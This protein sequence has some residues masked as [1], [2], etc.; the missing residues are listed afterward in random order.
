MQKFLLSFF[1]FLS[2]FCLSPFASALPQEH[3]AWHE[4]NN[5]YRTMYDRYEIAMQRAYDALS[6]DAY[7]KLEQDND[8]VID[9]SAK[10]A[11]DND[12]AFACAQALAERVLVVEEMVSKVS[13]DQ[14]EGTPN[15]L[16][17]F[18]RLNGR[19]GDD[20]Y[21]TIS[22]DG[23]GGFCLEIGVWQKDAPQSFGW[24][25]AQSTTLG[26]NFSTTT[27]YQPQTADEISA[28]DVQLKITVKD[29]KAVITTTE[30]FRKGGYVW[31]S[32]GE[33]DTIKN[34]FLDGTYQR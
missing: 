33:E 11:S 23:N 24:T 8:A 30:A 25:Q 17:G 21:L 1:L 13:Q 7:K 29:G 6:E 5:D 34:I 12:A 20:G 10:N 32:K 4:S 19:Q 22:R 27:V 14:L 2:S 9:A 26:E 16:E 3:D 15:P 18:Y 28:K 31:F